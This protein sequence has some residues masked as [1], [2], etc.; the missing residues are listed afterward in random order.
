MDDSESSEEVAVWVEE[1]AI[2]A[3]NSDMSASLK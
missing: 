2:I 1:Q 3:A